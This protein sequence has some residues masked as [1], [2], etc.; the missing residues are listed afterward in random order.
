MERRAEQQRPGTRVPRPWGALLLGVVVAAGLAACGADDGGTP[1]PTASESSPSGDGSG[2]SSPSDGGASSSP[3]D[4]PSSGPGSDG[5]DSAQ[6]CAPTKEGVPDDADTVTVIDVDGDGQRD[7]AWITPG[8]DRRFGIT[9]ASGA[10]FSEAIDSASPQ[11]ASA[12]VNR[13]GPND[14][15]I[16]LL[17]TGRSVDLLLLSGCEVRAVKNEQGQPYTFDKGFTGNGTGVACLQ[18]GA[19]TL[20]GMLA[21]PVDKSATRFKVTRTWVELS[22]DGTT[23]KNGASKT[24]ARAVGENDKD[25]ELAQETSCDGLTAP[26]D[27]PVEPES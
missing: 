1:S 27:G 10:T 2:S 5:S 7:T 4:G 18:D 20:A 8:A 3:G 17:D 25:L 22:D 23:A 15:P 6:A 11:R 12:V 16:A 14:L 24:L 9:T 26:P 13:V 19:L 21:E